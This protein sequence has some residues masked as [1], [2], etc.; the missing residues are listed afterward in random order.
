MKFSR[1]SRGL[2]IAEKVANGNA[3][4]NA[5]VKSPLLYPKKQGGPQG[6]FLESL[7]NVHKISDLLNTVYDKMA[8]LGKRK[9]PDSAGLGKMDFELFW[10]LRAVFCIFLI[11]GFCTKI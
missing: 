7:Q 5:P 4:K 6:S 9:R 3:R 8:D 2:Q 1:C 10:P 11:C